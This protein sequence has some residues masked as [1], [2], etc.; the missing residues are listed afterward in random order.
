VRLRSGVALVVT[1]ALGVATAA[2]PALAGSETLPAV[3]AVNV[4]GGIYGEE[5]H[6]SPAQV[7]VAAGGTVSLSNPSEVKH[8]VEW[9]GGPSTPSCSA[10]VPVGATAAASGV[11]WSGSCTFAAAGVYTFYCTVHGAAMSGRVTVGEVGGTTTTST[12]PTS[13][14]SGS[15]G[16][17]APAPEAGGAPAM[18]P[19]GSSG[20]LLS[21]SAARA[22]K[23]APGAR[24]ATIRGS[25]GLSALA[26]GGHLEVQA[27]IRRGSRLLRVGRL[28]R[29][30]LRAGRVAFTLSLDAGAA[31]SLRA[32]HRLAVTVRL[33]L[34]PLQGRALRITRSLVLHR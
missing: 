30:R 25:L 6:W 13:P 15:G 27:L 26:A 3:E 5:H 32:D 14:G 4:G 2:L 7:S 12:T 1:A 19:L 23:L 29:S 22:I 16:G 9:V 33:A 8:G 28:E 20:S 10:G 11:K 18:T 34:V 24:A 17:S 21:A 31:R